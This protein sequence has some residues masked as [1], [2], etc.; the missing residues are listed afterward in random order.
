MQAQACDV[1]T[2]QVAVIAIQSSKAY[3]EK[4]SQ[5]AGVGT[6]LNQF[7]PGCQ[8]METD[9]GLSGNQMDLSSALGIYMQDILSLYGNIVGPKYDKVYNACMEIM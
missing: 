3:A 2:H 1:I 6:P 8:P 9:S 4:R 5:P 7:H